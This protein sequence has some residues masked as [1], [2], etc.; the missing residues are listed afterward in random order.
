MLFNKLLDDWLHAD[1]DDGY[2][3]ATSGG[4]PC[5]GSTQQSFTQDTK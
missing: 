5:I 2:D 3:S 1:F 4:V